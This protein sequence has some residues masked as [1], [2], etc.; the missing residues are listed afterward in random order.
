M[1]S[2]KYSVSWLFD[3][4]T[5][6]FG[7][8]TE[9]FDMYAELFGMYTEAFGMYTDSFVMYTEA[10]CMHDPCGSSGVHGNFRTAPV[11]Q[12]QLRL[13]IISV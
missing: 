7:M 3:M 2:A 13:V 9:I 10:F 4:N 11:K 6:S 1:F 12:Q 5:E 8:Y